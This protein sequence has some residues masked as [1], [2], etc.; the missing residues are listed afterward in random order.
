MFVKTVDEYSSAANGNVI[1]GSILIKFDSESVEDLGAKIVC[2]IFKKY[3]NKVPL[4]I[5]FGT[6]ENEFEKKEEQKIEINNVKKIGKLSE[7]G[8]SESKSDTY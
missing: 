7:I 6:V 8:V 5:T 3:L 4:R 1:I 2:K